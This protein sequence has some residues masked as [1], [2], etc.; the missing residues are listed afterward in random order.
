MENIE[1]YDISI[2]EFYKSHKIDENF[3][4]VLYQEQYP[5][6]L[7]FYQ[8]YCQQNNIDDKHRLYFHYKKYHHN[9]KIYDPSYLNKYIS[10]SHKNIY[11]KP[12]F[13][14]ANRLLLINSAYSFATQFGFDGIKICWEK[15]SGFS[16]NHFLDLFKS[17]ISN[18][19]IP[20][21]DFISEEEYTRNQEMYLSLDD[22]IQQ[23]QFNLQYSYNPSQY[24]LFEF[25]TQNT[26][27]YASFACLEYLFPNEIKVDNIFLKSLQISDSLSKRFNDYILPQDIVGVHIRK[28]DAL[29]IE[30]SYKYTAATTQN[31]IDLI[32]HVI[33]TD[34]VFLSTDCKKTQDKIIESCP[35]K[36]ILTT[37]KP[38]VDQALTPLSNKDHQD[39]ACLDFM[40]L[41]KCKHVYGTPFS[42][43]AKTATKINDIPF[44]EVHAKNLYQYCDIKLPPLSLTVGIKNRYSQLRVALMSWILQESIDEILI[45]DWDSNDIDYQQLQQ[46]DDRIRIIKIDNQPFYNHS[47]V[48]N[49]CIKY[50]KNDH[51]LKMDVDYILN[52]YIKLNQWLDIDWETEFMAGSWNQNTL[53]NKIG[54]IEHLNGFMSIHKKHIENIGGY[55]EDFTGYGWEDCELYIRLQKELGLTKIIPP[56]S[57]NF[58]PIY[59][60]PHMDNI[61]TKYQIIKN[62]EESRLLNRSKTPH[63]SL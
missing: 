22:F 28:G 24:T 56:L 4:E 52:P 16:D 51:L 38:F 44:T 37:N 21:I 49:T 46:M 59:H 12:S 42:T 5:E 6:T 41:T 34:N 57:S 17:S 3:N 9:I 54:F 39:H 35:A 10:T 14:L 26:F 15:S 63:Q 50:A 25:I 13:G 36:K 27:Y 61:R 55:N 62:R 60:N 47:Q 30:H 53:D 20:Y 45:I 31:Y 48:L 29:R 8:P 18:S 11:L 23:N 33:D 2:E 40:L 7:D 43:F 58:M 32:N 19:S 1:K